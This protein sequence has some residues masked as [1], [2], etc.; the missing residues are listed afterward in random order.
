MGNATQAAI[1]VA[2]AGRRR[3]AD[4]L[5]APRR[6]DGAGEAQHHDDGQ[7]IADQAAALQ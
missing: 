1:R 7:Q 5:V 4:F 2:E 3:H 6:H